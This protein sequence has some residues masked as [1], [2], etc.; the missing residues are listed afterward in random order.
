MRKIYTT[1]IH[2]PSLMEE[3]IK[4]QVMAEANLIKSI[5]KIIVGREPTIDDAKMCTFVSKE[6]IPN[7]HLF[8]YK[9]SIMGCITREFKMNEYTV[10]FDP[11]VF[12][13]NC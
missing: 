8:Y 3:I 9:N 2:I 4:V 7:K 12:E 13:L 1:E 6:G 10:S 5:L 11:N